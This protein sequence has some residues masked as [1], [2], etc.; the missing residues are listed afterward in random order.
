[1]ND[2]LM[3][4]TYRQVVRKRLRALFCLCLSGLLE[5]INRAALRVKSSLSTLTAVSLPKEG[6]EGK[7]HA[8]LLI[9]VISV[10]FEPRNSPKSEQVLWW[11]QRPER[12]DNQCFHS[13]LKWIICV[14][15][16]NTDICRARN[17]LHPNGLVSSS[18]WDEYGWKVFQSVQGWAG[19]VSTL[20][21][22]L[23]KLIVLSRS[24]KLGRILF[25]ARDCNR[26]WQSRRS[27]RSSARSLAYAKDL[28]LGKVNK[29]MSTNY[30][31]NCCFFV[32]T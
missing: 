16:L 10:I 32:C 14:V 26:V 21:M 22:N 23:N 20:K 13:A 5:A 29:V 24:V 28:F 4:V 27:I 1:M 7:R 12:I 25:A 9:T 3:H 11:N 30:R 17:E 31:I 15:Q 8:E 18:M 19:W 6:L 2:W